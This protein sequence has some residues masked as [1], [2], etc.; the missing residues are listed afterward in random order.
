[1]SVASFSMLRDLISRSGFGTGVGAGVRSATHL[2]VR[3]EVRRVAGAETAVDC[4][5]GRFVMRDLV[6]TVSADDQPDRAGAST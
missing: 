6:V 5:E 4:P 1:M 2:G 3:C